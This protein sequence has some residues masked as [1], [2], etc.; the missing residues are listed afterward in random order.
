[1]CH[2]QLADIDGY[3]GLGV[4]L[5]GCCDRMSDR[6][7]KDHAL[8]GG[9]R[10]KECR[11]VIIE[12]CK[13]GAA[14]VLRIGGKIHSASQDSSL[15]LD[16]P[17][18]T[19]PHG[20]QATLQIRQK[21]HRGGCIAGQILAQR[22]IAGTI[23]EIAALQGREPTVSRVQEVRAGRKAIHGIHNH[24]KYRLWPKNRQK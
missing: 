11:Y 18:A 8:V 20:L 21:E 4:L 5:H 12:E 23:T 6:H 24:V 16:C 19:V 1:M 22:Q 14:K 13:A 9:M 17:V 2:P 3:Q 7:E 15:E 10:R